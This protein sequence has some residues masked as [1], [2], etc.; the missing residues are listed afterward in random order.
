ML[1]EYIT[2]NKRNIKDKFIICNNINLFILKNIFVD[3]DINEEKFENVLLNY[4]E[5]GFV[6]IINWRGLQM[7]VIKTIIINLIG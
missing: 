5:E 4:I 7:I 2:N 6:E 3:N 1:L